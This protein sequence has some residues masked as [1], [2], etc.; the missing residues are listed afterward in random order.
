MVTTDY[1]HPN[2][3][4]MSNFR[5]IN[6]VEK[7][8]FEIAVTPKESLHVTSPTTTLREL[9]ID[10]VKENNPKVAI[11]TPC[12]GGQCHLSY[13][14]C[15]IATIE[16]LMSFG[17]PTIHHTCKNDS[18]ITRAR[19]NLIA[20]AMSDPQTTH[21][22]FIDSDISWDATDIIK[23]LVSNKKLV[24]G[25]YP[26]KKYNWSKL[27][28]DPNNQFN[29]NIVQ[30]IIDKKLLDKINCHNISDEDMLR[31]NLVNYNVNYLDSNLT[32][33]DNLAKVRHIATGFMMI[34]RELLTQMQLDYTS[35][36]Y[37]DDVNFLSANENEFAYALF[38]CC[39][40][41]GHYLSEDWMFCDRW[42]QI[43]GDVFIDVSI[44]LTHTGIEDFKGAFMAHIV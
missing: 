38:D 32:I 11:L 12:Y 7:D 44:N 8:T 19:N 18:L 23:L 39:V 1:T 10:Y 29:T 16:L 37:V 36:K 14:P 2:L 24:G 17:I 41:D 6:A 3:D 9:I 5:V 13:I 27:L 42:R 34:Q 21:F 35:T 30:G 26:L 43:G 22:M 31:S 15:L 25:V 20:K 40:Q 28:V 33:K 4:Y